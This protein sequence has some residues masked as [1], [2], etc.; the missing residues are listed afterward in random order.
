MGLWLRRDV[1]ATVDLRRVLGSLVMLCNNNH[2]CGTEEF[3]E[4]IKSKTP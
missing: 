3:V 4:P 1:S 2:L